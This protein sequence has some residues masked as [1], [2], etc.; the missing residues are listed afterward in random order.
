MIDVEDRNE[1]HPRTFKIPSKRMR[2]SL[3]SGDFAKLI[4]EVP[5]AKGLNGE[6]MWVRILETLKGRA[7]VGTLDNDPIVLPLKFGMFI[8]F[9]PEHVCDLERAE[10]ESAHSKGEND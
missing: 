2:R 4:F 5:G 7:Y 3:R 10:P 6:R 1:Q 9:G 8:R